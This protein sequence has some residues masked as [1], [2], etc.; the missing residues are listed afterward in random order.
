MGQTMK[1]Y[2]FVPDEE[3]V[4]AIT[5]NNDGENGAD[6]EAGGTEADSDSARQIPWTYG[7]KDKI[8]A[9][10]TSTLLGKLEKRA[11]KVSGKRA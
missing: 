2:E 4:T 1:Q 5:N 7:D 6:N 11:K 3:I 9:L 8:V 10:V